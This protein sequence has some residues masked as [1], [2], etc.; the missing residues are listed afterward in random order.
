[1]QKV[2]KAIGASQRNYRIILTEG[3][4]VRI[5]YCPKCNKAGLKHDRIHPISAFVPQLQAYRY[6]PEDTIFLQENEV[7]YLRGEKYC[8]RC[9]EWVKPINHPYI[10]AKGRVEL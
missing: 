2:E 9:K 3:R 4:A 10:G 6:R 5:D 7:H 1:M 8:A